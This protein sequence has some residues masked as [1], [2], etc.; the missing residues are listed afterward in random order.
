MARMTPDPA[1]LMPP[2]QHL[3]ATILP[4]ANTVVERTTIAML[5]DLPVA[6]LFTR[7][8]KRGATDPFP[9]RHDTEALLAAAELLA[10]ARPDAIVPSAGKGA[11]IGLEHDRA[12]VAAI[13][14]RTGIPAD[15]PG[16]ALLRALG[17]LGATRIALIGPHDVGYNARAAHGLAREGI[18][19]LAE[20]SLGMTDN[21]SFASVG[22]DAVAAMARQ[23]ARAPGVQA[24]VAWNTNCAAAPLAAALEAELGLP[25]LDATAL[26]VWGGLAVAGAATRLGPA[27]GRLFTLEA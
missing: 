12:L 22:F 19:T 24:V 3:L 5:R 7:V 11:V 13:R 10:D 16:L 2:A 4:S 27:W 18:E 1:A 8:A 21:L 14:A 6:P 23:V 20:A 25:F 17:A 15:T 9:D 26:G